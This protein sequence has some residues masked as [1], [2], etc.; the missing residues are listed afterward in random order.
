M[1]RIYSSSNASNS[2]PIAV[3]NAFASAGISSGRSLRRSSSVGKGWPVYA[4]RNA[5]HNNSL[6]V[7]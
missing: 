3:I 1:K 7:A 5:S 4:C 6:F 2:I